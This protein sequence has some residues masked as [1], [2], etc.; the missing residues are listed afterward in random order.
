MVYKSLDIVEQKYVA[1]KKLIFLYEDGNLPGYFLREISILKSLDSKY[2][3]KLLR[4]HIHNNKIYLVFELLETDLE[5]Y[6]N[7]KEID[8][9]IIKEIMFQLIKA[10]DYIHDKSV[11]HRDIKPS[12]VLLNIQEGGKLEVKLG[13]FGLSRRIG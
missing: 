3:T 1:I 10:V 2:V 12:N 13:D 5:K 6:M 11:L 7:Q 8:H 4:H 9:S